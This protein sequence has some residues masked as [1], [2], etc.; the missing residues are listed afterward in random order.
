MPKQGSIA[1]DVAKYLKGK[2]D[3]ATMPEIHKAVIRRRGSGVLPHYV[4]SAVYS[5]LG[6]GSDTV[7]RV[8]ELRRSRYRLKK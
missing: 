4:R 6:K 1:W 8:G 5:H 2:P 3:G 7:E